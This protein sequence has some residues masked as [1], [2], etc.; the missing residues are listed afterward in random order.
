MSVQML[1]QYVSVLKQTRLPHPHQCVQAEGNGD[2][3]ESNETVV[4]R[5]HQKRQHTHSQY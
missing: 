1:L 5:D 2:E 4:E 3:T